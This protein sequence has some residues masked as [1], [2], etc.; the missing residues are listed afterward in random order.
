[1]FLT[2]NF[3]LLAAKPLTVVGQEC[4]SKHFHLSG[5]TPEWVLIFN[6]LK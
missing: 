5:G 1:M 2:L 3:S 6:K 4:V